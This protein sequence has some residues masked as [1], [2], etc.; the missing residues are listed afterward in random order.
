MRNNIPG[1]IQKLKD[2]N[3]SDYGDWL[4]LGQA[5]VYLTYLYDILER[6]EGKQNIESNKTLGFPER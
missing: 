2:I 5:T 1:L 4:V 6:T 3:C